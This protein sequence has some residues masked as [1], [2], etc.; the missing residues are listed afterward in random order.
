MNRP[1]AKLM[2]FWIARENQVISITYK[3]LTILRGVQHLN[4]E[5]NPGVKN[6]TVIKL[7]TLAFEEN[8]ENY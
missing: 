4:N 3:W 8:F 6:T 5:P 1:V 7:Y 2:S